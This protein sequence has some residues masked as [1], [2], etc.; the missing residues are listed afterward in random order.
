[1]KRFQTRQ[2]VSAQWTRLLLGCVLA[3]PMATLVALP[4]KSQRPIRLTNLTCYNVIG[5]GIIQDSASDVV[6]NRQVY[7]SS[8]LFDANWSGM[9][10][11]HT[12]KLPLNAQTLS[13]TLMF[14]DRIDQNSA[15]TLNFYVDGRLAERVSVQSGTRQPVRV[16]LSGGSNLTIEFIRRSGSR[17]LYSTEAE[18]QLRPGSGRR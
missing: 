4:A 12:C 17:V 9:R 6:V 3:L 2:F 11:E 1:M 15:W 16:D 14:D 18:I 5:S 10:F 8:I 7:T 13:L